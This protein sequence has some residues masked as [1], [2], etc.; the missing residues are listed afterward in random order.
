MVFMH[1]I[2]KNNSGLTLLEL[3]FVIGI[4]GILA[5][6]AVPSFISYRDKARITAAMQTSQ[7]IR[8]AFASYAQSQVE[9]L[10][11]DSSEISDWDTLKAM[12]RD[13]GA[14]LNNTEAG[15]GIQF[16]SYTVSDDRSSHNAPAMRG[17]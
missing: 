3:L 10:Y 7:S 2:I 8:D 1:R 11:P 5:A 16:V 15:Q 14:T 13:N 17:A 12:C 9:N 6:I 4:I